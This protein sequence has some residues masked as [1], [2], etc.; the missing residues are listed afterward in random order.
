M[1]TLLDPRKGT[2]KFTYKTTFFLNRPG[3]PLEEPD[4]Q[5]SPASYCLLVKMHCQKS[6]QCCRSKI[7]NFVSG[8]AFPPNFVIGSAFPPNFVS[9][10][11]F[12]PNFVSESAIPPNFGLRHLPPIFGWGVA[13]WW[14]IV[15]VKYQLMLINVVKFDFGDDFWFCH[16]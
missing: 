6:I 11:A 10:S 8:S 9:G 13:L 4:E 1:H 2:Q 7:F 14:I 15:F 12:P 5:L 3:L 16:L